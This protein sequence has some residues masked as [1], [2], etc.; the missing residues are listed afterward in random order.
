MKSLKT[1]L[2]LIT[3]MIGGMTV[4]AQ[5]KTGE[6]QKENDKIT[7]INIKVD[8]VC[9]MCKDRIENALDVKG[10]KYS[11]WDKTTHNCEITYRNDKIT[12]EEIH[13]LLNEA[14]HDTEK[15]TATQ[16]QYDQ[17]HKCCK[18]RDDVDH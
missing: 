15:S 5:E 1:I 14:G 17:V 7:T 8:G 10:V 9:G 12:E 11:S 16:A 18:Y 2:L 6:A 4:M 3:F 13:K